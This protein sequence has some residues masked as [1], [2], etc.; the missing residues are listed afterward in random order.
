MA[1]TC[2]AALVTA[3][4]AWAQVEDDIPAPAGEPV[5]DEPP[6]TDEGGEPI[7]VTGTLI[8]GMDAPTGGQAIAVTQADIAATGASS[9][10][11]LLAS[12]PQVTSG[13][14]GGGGVP[15]TVA[16]SGGG[17]VSINRPT[18]RNFGDR[19]AQSATTLLLLDGHRLPGMGVRQSSPDADVI[20]PG[21]IERVEIVPDGGSS[22]YG[23]DAVGGVINYIS[24]KKFDGAQVKARYGFADDYKVF[25]AEATVGK[26]WGDVSAWATYAYEFHDALF[27]RDR[28][29]INRFDF[30]SNA[31]PP[32]T[33]AS[34]QC[35]PGNLVV[36]TGAAAGTYA[37]PG[38]V[39]GI[40][41]RCDT[42]DPISVWPNQRRHSAF[43]A[44]NFDDGG[45]VTFGLNGY[46][47]Y[48]KSVS[49][50]GPLLLNAVLA[51]TRAGGLPQPFYVNPVNGVA[52]GGV[53]ETFSLSLAPVLGT[54]RPQTTTTEA[55]EHHA[56]APGRSRSR[57]AA[58]R[59]RQ[60]RPRPCRVQEPGPEQRRQRHGHQRRD[61]GGRVRSPQ[62][63]HRDDRGG[64]PPGRRPVRFR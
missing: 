44:V 51:P 31:I 34:L 14:N 48:R 62:H 15:A 49:F 61:R 58:Q 45:A 20:A 54:R 5:A 23:S 47:F 21:V 60:P 3:S 56:Q 27:G 53:N 46:Y 7:V 28:D 32:G 8:R 52:T 19:A 35:D 40:G 38:L 16:G 64:D 9:G 24:R 26:D 25:D 29:F 37:L 41:N 42:S 12:L 18:L 63:H 13:F 39:R 10:T 57:L 33:G 4:P 30:T 36:A 50:G 43:A 22:T 59:L 17:Q 6:V 2:L 55:Y 1:G 11:E